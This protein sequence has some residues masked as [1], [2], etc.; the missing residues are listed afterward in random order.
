MSTGLEAVILRRA[1]MELE[2]CPSVG[3]G[4]V[5][6]TVGDV[7]VLRRASRDA[8]AAGIPTGMAAFP[9]FPFCGRIAGARFRFEDRDVV[10][11][12]NFPPEP[13]AIHGRAWQ[14]AWQLEECTETSASL[15]YDSASSNAI[16]DWPW[17]Y[18]ATQRF[19]LENDG[20]RLSLSITNDSDARMPAGLGWHPYFRLGDARLCA[21][22]R[23]I[24]RSGDDMITAGPTTL[25][26]SN[27]LRSPRD[28]SGLE[29][30]DGFGVGDA[31]T[32]IAWPTSGIRASL[33]ATSALRHLIVFTPPGQDFFCVEPVS[34]APDAV[35]SA[36][37]FERTGSVVL[38]AG[39]RL[40]AE[41]R[42]RVQAI[43]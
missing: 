40:E 35:N 31:R 25:D 18:R 30:D 33:E 29:F 41:I 15:L 24:W 2:L 20:L 27:D 23:E 17:P 34:H 39:E 43:S 37:P 9:L 28:V 5:A 12:P 16:D 8:I 42:L 32:E 11:E 4:V 36:L 6:F 21:D 3:G 26:A 7:D 13:H 14:N 19:V 22:V 1:D 10:L 38:A